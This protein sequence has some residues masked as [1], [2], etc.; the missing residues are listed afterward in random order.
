MLISSRARSWGTTAARGV[1][2][3]YH[4]SPGLADHVRFSV[5]TPATTERLIVEITLDLDG[6]GWAQVNTGFGSPLGTV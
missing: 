3:R 5:G 1:L 4:N 6:R 2:I